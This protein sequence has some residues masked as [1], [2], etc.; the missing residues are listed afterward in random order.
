MRRRLSSREKFRCHADETSPTEHDNFAAM[1]Q[2]GPMASDR[3][4]VDDIE[5]L[6]VLLHPT[7]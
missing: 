3:L 4:G 6:V 2:E 1:G 7:A 5:V